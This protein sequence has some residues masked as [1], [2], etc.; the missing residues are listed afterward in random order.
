QAVQLLAEELGHLAID[1]RHP[2]GAGTETV[3][4]EMQPAFD[5]A[6]SEVRLAVLPVV[7]R[8]DVRRGDHD[9]GRV[10]SEPC[11][12]THAVELFAHRAAAG[13]GGEIRPPVETRNDAL[14]IVDDETVRKIDTAERRPQG[15]AQC[16]LGHTA[17]GVHA[18]L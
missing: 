15:D 4:K 12:P 13:G 7:E 6:G 3:R 9:E 17:G 1:E 14:D 18:T 10:A 2:A 5:Q 16:T 11:L 8:T